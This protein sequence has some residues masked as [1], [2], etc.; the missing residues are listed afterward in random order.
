MS[1]GRD[2]PRP[3][4]GSPG[5]FALADPDRVRT[6]LTGAGFSR[7]TLDELSRPMWFG[8]E[9]EG[10]RSFVL[11]MLGWMLEGLDDAGR[12]EA[13][14]ALQAN[15]NEHDTGRGIFYESAV[16]TVRASA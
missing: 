16:W 13:L 4:A 15:L 7:V 8:D 10:A 5:P 14:D 12:S 9:V 3:P 2:L 1:A 11:G 6:V